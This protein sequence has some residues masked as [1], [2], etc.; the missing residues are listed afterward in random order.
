MGLPPIPR[1][2][3]HRPLPQ[4]SSL[5][6]AFSFFNPPKKNTLFVYYSNYGVLFK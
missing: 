6:R 1:G 5:A 4:Q 2:A 3:P